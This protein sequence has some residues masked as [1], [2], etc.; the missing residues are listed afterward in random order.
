[1]S[2]TRVDH[3][4]FPDLNATW[5]HRTGD[6]CATKDTPC[7]L[8]SYVCTRRRGHTGRHA[9]GNGQIILKTWPNERHELVRGVVAEVMGRPWVIM[10]CR[11]GWN[12]A[13][14]KVNWALTAYCSH[15]NE[16]V[17]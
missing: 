10:R 11:C 13:A 17:E 15:A 6:V 14:P 9:A 2:T 8:H 7:V 5:R 4:G 3:L 16:E 1:M 12:H